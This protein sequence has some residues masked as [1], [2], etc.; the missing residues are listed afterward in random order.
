MSATTIIK[1]IV[2]RQYQAGG[3]ALTEVNR[4]FAG[5]GIF[6]AFMWTARHATT[7]ALNPRLDFYVSSYLP[8][9]LEVRL[10][11]PPWDSL[12]PEH[13]FVA[14]PIDG[15]GIT[16]TCIYH[17]YVSSSQTGGDTIQMGT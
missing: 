4:V 3:L 11:M 15:M 5:V 16:I 13:R 17:I 14:S 10:N 12:C 8:Q 1:S 9:F 6:V 7:K 2:N